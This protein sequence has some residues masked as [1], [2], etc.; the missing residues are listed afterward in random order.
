MI[1][2]QK[3][4]DMY[5]LV[6]LTDEG[7]YYRETYRSKEFLSANKLPGRYIGDR[8]YYSSIYYL[9]TS[10]T[11]SLVHRIKSDEVFHFYSGY[12]VEMLQLYPEGDGK[13][14]TLG[15]S[16]IDGDEFQLRVSNGVWMGMQLK[17]GGEYA[18]MGTSVSPGFEFDD[19]ELASRDI[20]I[21]DYPEFKN[22]ILELTR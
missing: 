20:L 1:D 17:P 22:K 18:L 3:I 10:E 2:A 16:I 19:L 9:L 14:I 12:P 7:G 11:K 6:P 13:T 8:S 5:R 15:N 4:I 21:R